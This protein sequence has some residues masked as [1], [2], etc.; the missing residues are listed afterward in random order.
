MRY[1]WKVRPVDAP[2]Q[3]QTPEMQG[4][5]NVKGPIRKRTVIVNPM[6]NYLAR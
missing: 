6:A 2:G 1:I 4:T 5:L 3:T